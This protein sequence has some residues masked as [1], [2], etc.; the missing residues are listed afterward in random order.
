MTV[1]KLCSFDLRSYITLYTI[2]DICSFVISEMD[3]FCIPDY[4]IVNYNLMI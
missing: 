1:I 3:I 4:I 2:K